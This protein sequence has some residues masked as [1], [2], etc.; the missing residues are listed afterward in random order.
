[1]I[2][3]DSIIGV[4]RERTSDMSRGLA[5]A[6]VVEREGHVAQV[7]QPLGT[8]LGM[9]VQAGPLV[10]DQHCGPDVVTVGQRQVPDVATSGVLVL[11]ALGVHLAPRIGPIA[12]YERSAGSV[13]VDPRVDDP[14]PPRWGDGGSF[15]AFR[16]PTNPNSGVATNCW[17]ERIDRLVHRCRS[18]G[19]ALDVGA[20]KLGRDRRA[21]HRDAQHE[22]ELGRRSAGIVAPACWSW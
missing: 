8:L 20:V 11:D 22:A 2:S 17:H 4:S 10:A 16:R 9:L 13:T 5:V 19:D 6:V 14:Q 15:A 21:A 7:R 1:M 18:G 3:G 12:R